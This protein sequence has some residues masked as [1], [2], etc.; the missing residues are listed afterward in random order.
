MPDESTLFLEHQP[1]LVAIGYRVLGS[2]ADAEDVA[3]EAWLRWATT[4]Q[5]A[6]ES[7]RRFLIT[8]VTRLAIDRLRRAHRRHEVYPGPWLPEPV[9]TGKLGPAE[10][11]EQR[12]TVSLATMRLMNQLS[13]PERAVFVLREGFELPYEEIGR[14]LDLEE[15]HARQLYRRATARLSADRERF[16]AD[17]H[18]HRELVARFLQAARTGDR[19]GLQ[20]LLAQEVTVW[21]D[22]GG[23]RSAALRPVVGAERASRLVLGTLGKYADVALRIADVNG[24]DA[25]LVRLGGEWQVCSFETAGGL[26]TGIQWMSNPEKLSLFSG[27]RS[28]S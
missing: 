16:P 11:A 26:I 3:Q 25:L 13:A 19:A 9:P 27:E 12:D 4:D 8:V 7:P 2:H 5:A 18:R 20:R 28:A 23:K 17:P 6:V 14:A 22:G 1:L 21:I 24:Q 10:T 15:A